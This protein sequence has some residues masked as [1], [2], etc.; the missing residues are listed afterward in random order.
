MNLAHLSLYRARRD[1]HVPAPSNR[2]RRLAYEIA[3]AVMR[4]N[5]ALE[6]DIPW[7]WHNNPKRSAS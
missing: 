7:Q 5:R 6:N 1:A 2:D 4:S 3:R